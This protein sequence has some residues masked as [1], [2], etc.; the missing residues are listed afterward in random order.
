MNL[1]M[2][3]QLFWKQND[4]QLSEDNPIFVL[5]MWPFLHSNWEK[6][7]TRTLPRTEGRHCCWL[8]RWLPGNL[9]S[10]KLTTFLRSHREYRAPT[11]NLTLLF[12]SFSLFVFLFVC[13]QF[14]CLFVCSFVCLSVCLSVICLFVCLCSYRSASPVLAVP[15]NLYSFCSNFR[16]ENW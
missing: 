8:P 9:P 1:L 5:K 7:M 6:R 12:F 15:Q 10:T 11:T 16:N 13:L 14:V 4:S 2:N 3:R